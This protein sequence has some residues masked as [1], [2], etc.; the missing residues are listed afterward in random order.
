MFYS[1]CSQQ[2]SQ[3]TLNYANVTS[4]Y[5][6]FRSKPAKVYIH[7]LRMRLCVCVSAIR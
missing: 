4:D 1:K 6:V 2:D 5:D 3:Y 7:M